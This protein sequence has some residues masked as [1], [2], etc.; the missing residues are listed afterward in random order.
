M[1]LVQMPAELVRF[2]DADLDDA[3]LDRSLLAAFRAYLPEAVDDRLGMAILT[4]A[5]TGGHLL[6]MVLA[7]QIGAALRDENIDL[8]DSGGDIKAAKKRLCYLPGAVL[9]EALTLPDARQTLAD[10]A[11]CFLQDLDAA[12]TPGESDPAPLANGPARPA[13]DAVRDLLYV[14]LAAGRPTF[15]NADPA[16]LPPGIEAALRARLRV[17]Q[18]T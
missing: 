12:W 18:P 9:P 8:R 3:G 2:S 16:G 17:I 7:R 1:K 15:L 14:R 4:P 5:G 10:E 6:L 11:A 13:A